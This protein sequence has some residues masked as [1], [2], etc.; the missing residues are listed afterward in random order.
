MESPINTSF[1]P[2]NVGNTKPA[3]GLAMPGGGDV[4]VVVSIVLLVASVALAAGVFLYQGYLQ[5]ATQAK[6]SALDRAKAAFEPSLIAQ[7]TRLDD[8]MI[9]GE[10]LLETHIA[11]TV[12]LRALEQSTLQSVAFDSL[13]F[14]GTDKTKMT[15]R[16]QGVA[17]SVNA[18]ALQADMFGKTGVI[19]SPIFSN[20]TRQQDGIHFDVSAVVSPSSITYVHAAA[21]DTQNAQQTPQQPAPQQVQSQKP[22]GS[23]QTPPEDVSAPAKQQ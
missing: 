12:I 8:R 15:L 14:S 19:T 11:P 6:S 16:M 13:S 23:Q 21:Q 7:L 20:I 5:T 2:A 4:F 17:K 1:I 3:R 18:I 9:A 22:Q 10:K